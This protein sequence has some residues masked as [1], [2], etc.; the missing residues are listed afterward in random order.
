MSG[1][2]N[3]PTYALLFNDRDLHQRMQDFTTSILGQI[4]NSINIF[5]SKEIKWNKR[6]FRPWSCTVR[7]YWAGENLVQDRLL[8]LLTSSP[9][10]YHCATDA[11]PPP[12]KEKDW[13][14]HKARHN[15]LQHALVCYDDSSETEKYHYIQTINI[16]N[17][18]CSRML[19]NIF[20]SL[21]IF[22][23]KS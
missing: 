19:G 4:Y 15:P 9:A 10:W 16:S 7:L 18:I 12:S 5:H 11:P 23:Y 6:C 8:N 20:G 21:C 1:S 3:M 2:H 22:P 14:W 13:V 17:A